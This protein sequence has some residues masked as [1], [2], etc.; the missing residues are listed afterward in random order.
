MEDEQSKGLDQIIL[1]AFDAVINV[2]CCRVALLIIHQ[3]DMALLRPVS[4]R[5]V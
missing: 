5:S 1:S 3:S 2:L 4:F